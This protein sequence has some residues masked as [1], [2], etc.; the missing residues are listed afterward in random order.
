MYRASDAFRHDWH[1]SPGGAR[2]ACW[3]CHGQGK[4]R[5][6]ASA[7]PC[8][9]CH[10]DLVP[11]GA[12]IQVKQYQATGYAQAMHVLCIGCHA[13]RAKEEQKPDLARC[14]DCHQERRNLIDARD[15]GLPE[16][17]RIGRGMLL[18]RISK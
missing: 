18:P 9:K 17:E 3:Q 13:R 15:L 2:L 11:A 4:V 12:T 1:Y 16:A 10:R 7:K 8:D 6:A 5:D 14:A